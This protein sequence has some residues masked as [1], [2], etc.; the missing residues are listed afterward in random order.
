MRG[1]RPK[2]WAE[3]GLAEISKCVSSFTSLKTVESIP[4]SWAEEADVG[5]SSSGSSTHDYNFLGGRVL[6]TPSLP[7]TLE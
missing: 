3:E 1:G 2:Q 4:F 6:V 7:P 5:T